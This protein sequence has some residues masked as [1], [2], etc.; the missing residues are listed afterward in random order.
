MLKLLKVLNIEAADGIVDV[1]G[2]FSAMAG[3]T[4]VGGFAEAKECWTS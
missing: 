4:L 1:A 3:V 2:R